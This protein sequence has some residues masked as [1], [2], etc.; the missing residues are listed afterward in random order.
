MLI[1]SFIISVDVT[2]LTGETRSANTTVYAGYKS[3]AVE[4]NLPERLDESDDTRYLIKTTNLAGTETP[5][6]G[7]FKLTKLG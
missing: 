4:M 3:L 5:A 7:E 1:F 6:K 2:D